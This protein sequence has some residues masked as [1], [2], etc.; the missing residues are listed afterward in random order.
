MLQ[1]KNVTQYDN[2]RN[3][4][5]ECLCDFKINTGY[6]FCEILRDKN[7]FR[8]FVEEDNKKDL[9]EYTEKCYDILDNIE[10]IYTDLIIR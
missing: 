4:L 3:L 8:S 2:K 6:D 5:N 7:K 10:K 9:R 1:Q